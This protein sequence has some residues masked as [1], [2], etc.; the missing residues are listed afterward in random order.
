MRSVDL[1]LLL[2][3]SILILLAVYLGFSVAFCSGSLK[4]NLAG[5]FTMAGGDILGSTTAQIATLASG[6]GM[7]YWL[8]GRRRR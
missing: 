7:L 2:S 4:G 5:C 1:V 8:I 3:A 6:A